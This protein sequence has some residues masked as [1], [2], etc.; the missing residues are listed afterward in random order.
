MHFRFKPGTGFF[1]FLLMVWL[2]AGVMWGVFCDTPPS[3]PRL[4]AMEAYPSSGSGKSSGWPI[5]LSPHSEP[6]LLPDGIDHLLTRLAL[7]HIPAQFT[8]EKQ[9]GMKAEKRRGVQLLNQQGK[10]DVRSKKEW[11]NH[12]NWRKYSAS[13]RNPEEEFQIQLRNI[14]ELPNGGI[15]FEVHCKGHLDFV[16]QQANWKNGIQLLS[17]TATGHTEVEVQI[18]LEVQTEFIGKGFLPDVI[19]RPTARQARLLV[20]DFRIDRIGKI[21]GELAKQISREARK[22]I[23]GKLPEQEQKIVDKIN[24]EFAKKEGGYRFSFSDT[25]DSKLKDIFSKLLES[26]RGTPAS[27]KK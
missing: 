27:S 12:G 3:L 19:I 14:Q 1:F 7:S 23:T 16:A 17:L 26:N 11:V 24:Q 2:V 22:Q 10:L 4:L 20:N 21:G 13:L 18:E 5:Q 8:E 15:G 25:H 6:L 9:W